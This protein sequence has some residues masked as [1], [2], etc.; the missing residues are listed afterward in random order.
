MLVERRVFLV[1]AELRAASD[2]K[3]I[4]GYAARYN[5]LSQPLPAG[6]ALKLSANGSLPARFAAQL[7]PART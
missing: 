6:K 5:T 2:G 7:T 3:T 1:D 4:T